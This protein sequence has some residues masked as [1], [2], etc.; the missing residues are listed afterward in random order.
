M[1][2]LATLKFRFR[3]A[4]TWRY[5]ASSIEKIIEEGVFVVTSEGLSLRALDTSHVAMVDLFYPAD[6]FDEWEVPEEEASFGVSFKEFTKVL[7]RAGKDDNLVIEV[8][9]ARI[10]VTFTALG[11]G[12]R[13]FRIP[14]AMLT[15]EKL[16]EPRIEYTVH[17]KMMGTT[18]REVIRDL[19]VIG[20]AITF[21]AIEGRDAIILRAVG[22]I[23][24]GEVELSIDDGTL[25]DFRADSPDSATYTMEYFS[26]MRPAAQAADMVSIHY[27]A[28]APIRVDMEYAGGGRLTFYVSP[29]FE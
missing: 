27:A 4:R 3:D 19:E 23:E 16:G 22:D 21:Q 29:R 6:A 25:I 13:M 24:S 15:Y 5:M 10:T 7:R 28:D 20:E 12:T 26:N 17:A 18:F 8:D 11:R 2:G 14:Q 1:P 9:E